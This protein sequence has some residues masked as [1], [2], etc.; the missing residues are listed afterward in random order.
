MSK[1]SYQKIGY[2]IYNIVEN[3]SNNVMRTFRGNIMQTRSLVKSL[4]E[5]GFCGWTPSFML[6]KLDLRRYVS[7]D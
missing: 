6:R 7:N 1:Y 4:E 3:D 2:N 5:K